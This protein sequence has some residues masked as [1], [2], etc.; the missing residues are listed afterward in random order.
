MSG[1]FQTSCRPPLPPIYVWNAICFV[2]SHDHPE[3]RTTYQHFE[4][5]VIILKHWLLLAKST[6]LSTILMQMW[7]NY[8]IYEIIKSEVWK[9]MQ[10]PPPHLENSRH[11]ILLIIF[12]LPLLFSPL[13]SLFFSFLFCFALFC[14]AFMN[15]SGL[16]WFLLGS[17]VF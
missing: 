1:I 15:S 13:F 2:T 11:F 12:T 10:S 8:T 4:M 16:V 6:V 17:K 14:C 9:G 5:G 3:M 7:M